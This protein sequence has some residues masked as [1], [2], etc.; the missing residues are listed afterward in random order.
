M[1]HTKLP[2][3]A[4][5][6]PDP[7][8]NCISLVDATR[9]DD[10][11]EFADGHTTCYTDATANA[12]LIVTAVNAHHALIAALERWD[13]MIT[14]CAGVPQNPDSLPMMLRHE[15]R[16]ALTAAQGASA[17]TGETSRG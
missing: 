13:D 2:W 17:D 11:R 5:N 4:V 14:N 16:T 7:E 15:I 1:G 12:A 10:M 8:C 9:N 6:H 3:I